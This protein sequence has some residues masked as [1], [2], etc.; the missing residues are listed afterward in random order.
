MKCRASGR[1]LS[2]VSFCLAMTGKRERARV[3]SLRTVLCNFQDAAELLSR[4]LSRKYL[5]CQF[6]LE[7]QSVRG[8]FSSSCRNTINSLIS[9]D[10]KR[11]L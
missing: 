2:L 10:G 3:L 11:D 4:Q 1:E 8:T 9:T 5:T 6:R 7:I